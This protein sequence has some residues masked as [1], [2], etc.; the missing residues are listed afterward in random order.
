MKIGTFENL[1]PHEIVV[2]NKDMEQHLKM[3]H[4][5]QE[6][7]EE[8]PL[9]ENE[10]LLNVV[11]GR[12]PKYTWENNSQEPIE[13]YKKEWVGSWE[14][15]EIHSLIVGEGNPKVYRLY[16]RDSSYVA[17][18]FHEFIYGKRMEGAFY[19]K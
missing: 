17:T 14:Q 5:V 4:R 16:N 12:I 9:P 13:P 7:R 8:K 10:I 2:E 19:K 6:H 3:I 15:F 18:D 11:M 1:T